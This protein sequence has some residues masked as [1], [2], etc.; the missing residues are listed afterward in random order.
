MMSINIIAWNCRGTGSR[1][2]LRHLKLLINRYKS[3]ILVLIETRV[4]SVFADKIVDITNFSDK[5]VVEAVRF[6][7]GIWVMWNGSKIDLEAVSLDDQII[8]LLVYMNGC[9]PWLLLAIY[10]SPFFDFC[11]HLWDYLVCLGPVV[12]CPW[13]LIGDFNQILYLEEKRRGSKLLNSKMEAF[14][15][16]LRKC[17]LVDVKFSGPQFTWTNMRDSMTNIQERLDRVL[18]NS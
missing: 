15:R 8:N 5:I 16:L 4:N 17:D 10:A 3:N 6:S 12:K 2:F 7:G 1:T 13:M 18:G 14:R 11:Q 9:V